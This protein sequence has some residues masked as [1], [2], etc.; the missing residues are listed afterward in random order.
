MAQAVPDW[1]RR[2]LE[3]ADRERIEARNEELAARGL[4][5]LALAHAV[6][7][8]AIHMQLSRQSEF[9]LR[10]AGLMPSAA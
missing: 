7:G 9:A 4:R 1:T 6:G 2:P 5:V 10:L 3:A 8:R